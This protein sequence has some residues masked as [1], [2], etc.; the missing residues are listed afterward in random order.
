MEEEVKSQAKL[1]KTQET[2]NDE[3]EALSAYV[4]EFKR[5]YSFL[6]Q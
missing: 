6:A 1:M 4:D 5:K 2:L 3:N